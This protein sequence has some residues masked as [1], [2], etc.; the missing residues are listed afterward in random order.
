MPLLERPLRLAG[1]LDKVPWLRGGMVSCDRPPVIF[2]PKRHVMANPT[3]IQIIWILSDR[4]TAQL[5]PLQVYT[6]TTTPD[7]IIDN[8]SGRGISWEMSAPMA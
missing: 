4:L 6:I 2:M 7:R 8:L 1:G 5:P 3:T